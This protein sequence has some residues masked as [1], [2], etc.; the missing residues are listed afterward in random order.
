MIE[1]ISEYELFR[2][3]KLHHKGDD[4]SISAHFSNNHSNF[5]DREND[6]DLFEKPSKAFTHAIEYELRQR[7]EESER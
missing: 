2:M 3:K 1:N 4:D 6:Q 5:T 7:L